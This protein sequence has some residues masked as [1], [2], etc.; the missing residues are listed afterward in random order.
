MLIEYEQWV[1]Q[2]PRDITDTAQSM[3]EIEG[4][5]VKREQRWV[6]NSANT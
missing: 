2:M 1:K 3:G 6:Q 5:Y 4:R